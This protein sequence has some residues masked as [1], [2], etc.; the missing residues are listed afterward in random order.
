MGDIASQKG[1][2]VEAG[3]EAVASR[4][5]A[6]PKK[7]FYG[8]VLIVV[9]GFMYFCSS[10]I[11]LPTATIVNPLMLQDESL[12]MNATILG[13]GFSLFVLVQGLS[14]PLVGGLIARKGARFS[15]VSGAVI[16]LIAMLLL[17]FFVSSPIAYFIVFGV[18]TSA[19]TMMVGQLAVQSTI[20]DWFVA[21]RGIAM[22]AMMVIGASASFIGP[23]VVNAI[24]GASGG[25][26][27]SGWYLLVVLSI[28]LIPVALLFVKNKPSDVGQYP[29]GA[30]GE[31]SLAGTGRSFKVYK[32]T[33]K[34]PFKEVLRSKY[35]WLLSLAATGGFAAFTLSTA[36]G[37]LHFGSLGFD[38]GLIVAG[39]A[40]MGGVSLVGKTLLGMISDRL[41]PVRLIV[42]STVVLVVGILL[43]AAAQSDAMVY[44]YYICIGLGFGGVNAVFPTA[45]ANYFGAFSFSKN[46]G[47]GIMITTVVAS[48]LPVMSGAI[49][50][51][52]GT[53]TIA[54]YI[55]AAIVAVCA[56][57]GL[58]VKIPKNKGEK[59][60]SE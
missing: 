10:G 47:T 57:C 19:A 31:S 51:A 1:A 59:T 35:F 39:V 34:V 15:M 4:Q 7:V 40:L 13:T 18:V 21:R 24:V 37:V 49:Y 60:A 23:P 46:L 20:G 3:T 8:Y 36:Q 16:M 42:I 25:S 48:T 22:T 6:K 45:M 27:Q 43:G 58:F 11:V 9:L 56:V 41:E 44:A 12:G 50:D 38:N 33:E 30:D 2:G 53:C 32:N 14:A 26:W 28:I 5:G 54:F 17:I 29:D 52:T 55:T